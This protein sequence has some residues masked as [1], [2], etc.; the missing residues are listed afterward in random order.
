[1]TYANGAIELGRYHYA[2]ASPGLADHAHENAWEICFLVKGWQTYCIGES[3]YRLRG[4]DVF[5]TRPGERHSTGGNPEEKGELYWMILNERRLRKAGGGWDREAK[6]LPA[7]LAKLRSPHFRGSWKM[8]ECLDEITRVFALRHDSMRGIVLE[9]LTNFFLIEVIRCGQRPAVGGSSISL[10]SVVRY[11]ESR[12]EEPFDVPRLAEQSGLSIAR[13]KAR[14]KAEMGVPPGEFIL[15]AKIGEACRR[16]R[17][18]E[19]SVTRVAYDLGFSSSQY[20]ATVFRRFM[21]HA[22]SQH[23]KSRTH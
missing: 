11:L 8:K 9:N 21:G 19:A 15:R 6:S 13:F 12:L 23:P 2:Q 22:P 16:L 10:L 18:P 1:M 17:H 20:F 5:L 14:F 4:G 3:A 7:A